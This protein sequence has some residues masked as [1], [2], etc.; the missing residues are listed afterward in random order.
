MDLEM[1]DDNLITI[2]AAGAMLSLSKWAAYKLVREGR[3]PVIRRLGERR[4]RVRK[5][6][7]R[8]IMQSSEG[9]SYGGAPRRI[10][11]RDIGNGAHHGRSTKARQ[12]HR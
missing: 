8:K 11:S 4:L 5:S 3:L 1:S 12:D 9:S 7:V 2:P 6:D 10:T